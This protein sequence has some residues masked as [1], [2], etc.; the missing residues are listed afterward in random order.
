SPS[1]SV[2]P[3]PSTSPTVSPS[4]SPTSTPSVPQ[5]GACRITYRPNSW[6][7]GFTADVTIT[8]T[9]TAPVNGWTVTWTWPGNQQ[10]TNAWNATVTQSGTQVTARNVSYNSTIPAGGSTNFGFQ[11]VYSGSNPNPT[12]FALNGTA[13]TVA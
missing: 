1:P 3:S 6:P 5:Q 10:V 11:G 9:G 8:N 4:P 13:C 7:G 2:S 12:A